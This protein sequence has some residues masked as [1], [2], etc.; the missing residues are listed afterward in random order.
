MKRLV[1]RRADSCISCRRDLPA[2][3]RAVWDAGTKTVRCTDCAP[4][5][6]P[7][8]PTAPAAPDQAGASAAREY[9]RRSSNRE[10]RIRSAHPKLGGLILA[11]SN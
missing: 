10:A 4:A 3:T 2:G 11:L 1:L 6:V 9:E 7:E 5:T 8:Q